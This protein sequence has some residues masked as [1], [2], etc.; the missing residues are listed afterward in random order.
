MCA[1]IGFKVESKN[2]HHK[3]IA[4]YFKILQERG[5]QSYGYMYVTPAGDTYFNKAL[6][7]TGVTKDLEDLEEGTWVFMHARKASAGMMGSTYEEKIVRAH[8]VESNDKRVTLL[9]NGT[10]TSLKDTVANS[11]SDSQALATL[12]SVAWEGRNTYYG[13]IGVVIYD[14]DGKMYLYK[15][16]LRPLVMSEDNTIFC[17]EPVTDKMKWKNI[18]ETYN[19]T[20]TG[21]TELLLNEDG[22]GLDMDAPIEIS[23]D[24]A[25]TTIK[26]YSTAG[27]PRVGYCSKCK[28]QHIKDDKVNVCCVCKVEGKT[29]T[30]SATTSYK[31]KNKNKKVVTTTVEKSKQPTKGSTPIAPGVIFRSSNV[32]HSK[33]QIEILLSDVNLL[34]RTGYTDGR[35]N[36]V[37][38]VRA[39][40]LY[41]AANGVLYVIPDADG[42]Y[43]VKAD[44][45]FV[46]KDE[47][48]LSTTH[49][50]AKSELVQTIGALASTKILPLS[51]NVDMSIAKLPNN[52]G[53]HVSREDFA[54]QTQ[55]WED[56]NK[57]WKFITTAGFEKLYNEG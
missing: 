15:D 14:L 10:K 3:N 32:V 56:V 8:P 37:T 27:Y 13:N 33:E 9:H 26:N 4:E 38:I 17:S 16:N 1:I 20:K 19:S 50:H 18:K 45:V 44:R 35:W 36:G 49:I 51:G 24:I 30:Y 2:N 5:D 57:E 22:L 48:R 46:A 6:Y 40:H 54:V 55:I 39:N 53:K 28:K 21:D 31:N 41:K 23:F 12:L 25:R 7:L 52:N 34:R 43:F 29:Y 47:K 42:K 11:A